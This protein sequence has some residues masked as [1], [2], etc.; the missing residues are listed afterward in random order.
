MA[1]VARLVFRQERLEGD[2]RFAHLRLR[3]YASEVAQ[4]GAAPAE[5]RHLDGTLEA[6]LANQVPFSF[7]P[8]L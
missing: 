1:P 7:L 8:R 6:A 2:L 4:Y 3:E 5:R